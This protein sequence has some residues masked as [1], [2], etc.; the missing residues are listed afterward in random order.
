MLRHRAGLSRQKM[1][2]LRCGGVGFRHH[3]DKCKVDYGR[4]CAKGNRTEAKS[5]HSLPRTSSGVTPTNSELIGK[6][7]WT[8]TRPILRTTTVSLYL[9]AATPLQT[10]GS[11]GQFHWQAET[12]HPVARPTPCWGLLPSGTNELETIRRSL[13]AGAGT[14]FHLQFICKLILLLHLSCPP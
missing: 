9:L 10:A 2:S 13:A 3:H 8:S 12:N 11:R 5:R 4:N 6:F 14:H 1:R 7:R